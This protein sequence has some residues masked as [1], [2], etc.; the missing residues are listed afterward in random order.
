MLETVWDRFV[1]IRMWLSEDDSVHS[2]LSPEVMNND[3]ADAVNSHCVFEDIW[4]RRKKVKI[5]YPRGDDRFAVPMVQL[6]PE[7]FQHL[8]LGGAHG[9]AAA[10]SASRHSQ[11][12]KE[13][14]EETCMTWYRRLMHQDKAQE[15]WA[16]GRKWHIAMVPASPYC[17]GPHRMIDTATRTARVLV[18]TALEELNLPKVLYKHVLDGICETW[19]KTYNKQV[20]MTPAKKYLGF[21]PVRTFMFGDQVVVKMNEKSLELAGMEITYLHKENSHLATVLRRAP[22]LGKGTETH[23]VLE[24][25]PAWLKPVRRGL[26]KSWLGRRQKWQVLEARHWSDI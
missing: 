5:D 16:A 11:R 10:V 26:N 8:E 4:G 7:R 21:P 1:L 23:T 9:L 14:D 13:A 18:Q 17:Y 22:V 25:H 2:F 19:N 24:V 6:H 3:K 12:L 15:L 20:G